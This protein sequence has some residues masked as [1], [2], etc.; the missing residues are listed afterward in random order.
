MRCPVW[1]GRR[2][3]RRRLS[4]RH[5]LRQSAWHVPASSARNSLGHLWLPRCSVV[6]FPVRR[7]FRSQFICADQGTRLWVIPGFFPAA[8]RVLLCTRRGNTVKNSRAARSLPG[9]PR[10]ACRRSLEI[11]PSPIANRAILPVRDSG[12][13]GRDADKNCGVGPRA[14]PGK[15]GS[16]DPSSEPGIDERNVAKRNQTDPQALHDSGGI[17]AD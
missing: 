6:L 12:S 11:A 9:G 2:V 4:S 14:T 13:A 17:L 1:R 10:L 8:P 7:F 3:S 15:S 16:D 5:P